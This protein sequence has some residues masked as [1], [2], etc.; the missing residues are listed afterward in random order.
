M[1]AMATMKELVPEYR[2]AAARLAM[3]AAEIDVAGGA[4]YIEP[5]DA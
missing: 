4:L 5:V 2:R 1:M 3:C